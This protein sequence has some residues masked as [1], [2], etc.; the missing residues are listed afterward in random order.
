M[1]AKLAVATMLSEA[2]TRHGELH[3]RLYDQCV[4]QS[5]VSDDVKLNVQQ[6]GC[7]P[8]SVAVGD[9]F[10]ELDLILY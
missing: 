3:Q 8:M 7:T 5:S 2:A 4:S 6:H 1:K 10:L 9:V